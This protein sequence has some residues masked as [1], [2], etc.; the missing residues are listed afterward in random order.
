VTGV[1]DLS[2][3]LVALPT[4]VRASSPSVGENWKI[5]M[6]ICELL[7]QPE[8]NY[9]IQEVTY[10]LTLSLFASFLFFAVIK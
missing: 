5:G 6:S 10:W 2:D 1:N 3:S 4:L 7:T 9:K 8:S